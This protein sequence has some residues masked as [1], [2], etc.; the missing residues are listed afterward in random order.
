MSDDVTIATEINDE[1]AN[2]QNI[3]HFCNNSDDVYHNVNNFQKHIGKINDLSTKISK[4]ELVVLSSMLDNLLNEMI[5]GKK[6]GGIYDILTESLHHMRS[7]M[8]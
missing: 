3:L 1:I 5:Q 4:E 7:S 2:I 8:N 6:N